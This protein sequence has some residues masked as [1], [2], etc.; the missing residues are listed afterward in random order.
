M[1]RLI[2]VLMPLLLMSCSNYGQI[3]GR[4]LDK[5]NG[6][7]IAGAT[8]TVKGTTTSIL[9]DDKG[10]FIL[11][12]VVPGIQKLIAV[13]ENYLSIGEIE[14]GIAKGTT[15]KASDLNLVAKPPSEGL[16]LLGDKPVP[17]NYVSE[18]LFGM[19]MN[20]NPIIE[21]STL[22][23]ILAISGKLNLMLYEGENSLKSQTLIY[24]ML[25]YPEEQTLGLV[26]ISSPERWV[27][28]AAI[29]Q[30]LKM[31]KP[32]TSITLITGQLLPGRY[33]V[34]VKH[35]Q[36]IED[37]YFVFDLSEKETGRP[38]DNVNQITHSNAQAKSDLEKAYTSSQAFFAD[39]PNFT[40]SIDESTLAKS[41]FRKSPGI[42]LLINNGTQ[43]GLNLSTT[44]NKGNKS[45]IIDANGKI[46]EVDIVGD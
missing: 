2:G 40:E 39:N 42:V 38:A 3:E 19:T 32:A 12:N 21:A 25:F 27:L 15:T 31:E 10:T 18:K 23:S 11:K 44:H 30:G 14:L 34:M 41:G 35:E 37:W 43:A 26:S 1:K 17:V 22:P 29:T 28:Q 36:G 9:T 33:C 46:T 4:V 24:P 7:A 6:K 45:Y 8:V 16:F 5:L 13:K 20:G